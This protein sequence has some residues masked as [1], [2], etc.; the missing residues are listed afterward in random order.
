MKL[1]SAI[2]IASLAAFGITAGSSGVAWAD[3]PGPKA[4]AAAQAPVAAPEGE[5][6]TVKPG[7]TLWDLSQQFLDD[8]FL[9][10][11]VWE[12][13][14]QIKDPDRIYP[15]DVLAL[16]KRE[17]PEEAPPP[18]AEAPVPPP[19]PVAVAPPPPPPGSP[20][21]PTPVVL[22]SG[23]IVPKDH[24]V[25]EVIG[26]WDDKV[27]LA[28]GDLVY[29]TRGKGPDPRIGSHLFVYKKVKAVRH[30][31]TGE[32]MGDLV[33]GMGLVEV[34]AIDGEVMTGRITAAYDAINYGDRLIPY[35]DPFIP[36]TTQIPP[37]PPGLSGYIV[38]VSDD[39]V[40]SSDGHIVYIDK[41]AFDGLTPGI[42]LTVYWQNIRGLVPSSVDRWLAARSHDPEKVYYPDGRI[43]EKEHLQ[44]P[45]QKV[46]EILILSVQERTATGQIMRSVKEIGP[47]YLVRVH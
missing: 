23:M 43:R 26:A 31:V 47:G 11:K 24:V 7:D 45:P 44:L 8:P 29:F 12:M 6:Y 27:L 4:P 14:P 33:K 5:R 42:R 46:G 15:G 3:E 35:E 20:I 16:P 2:F 34:T 36:L 10:P 1:T 38:E 37:P 21:A 30:P 17:R 40:L 13:N 39:R 28:T 9:W 32:A 41:G 18:V 25:R 19:P 22:S